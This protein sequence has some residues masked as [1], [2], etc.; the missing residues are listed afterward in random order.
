MRG[1]LGRVD[2][3]TGILHTESNTHDE[4][5]GK[6]PLPRL[7]TSGPDGCTE[8]DDSRDKDFA[9]S[10][11]QIVEGV[12]EPA[13]Y[14]ATHEVDER[15]DCAHFPGVRAGRA[16]DTKLLREREVGSV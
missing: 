8:Q 11:K 2:G 9:S 15:V 16:R 3:D 1:H 4:S 7:G 5:S 10:A 6:K 12:R 13:T 14:T